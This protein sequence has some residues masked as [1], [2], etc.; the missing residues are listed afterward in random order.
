MKR[1]T[2]A[3]LLTVVILSVAL[4]TSAHR[5]PPC[6]WRNKH[7]QPTATVTMTMTAAETPEPRDTATPA[8]AHP[9]YGTLAPPVVC[10]G[11]HCPRK[12]KS[13]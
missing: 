2:L 13:P 11:V 5:H 8:I 10:M 3:I 1:I 4:V 6:P 9:D 7:C 12:T